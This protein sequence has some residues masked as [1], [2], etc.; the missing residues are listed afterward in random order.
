MLAALA[1]EPMEEVG[2]EAEITAFNRHVDA[3][4]HE[5]NRIRSHF[6]IVSFVAAPERPS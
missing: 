3:L 5:G 4:A 6:S 1:R 2:S